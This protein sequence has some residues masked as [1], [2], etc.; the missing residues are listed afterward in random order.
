MSLMKLDAHGLST[1]AAFLGPF[2]F[3]L[4]I[5]L[6][7]FVCMSMFLTIINDSF[8]TVRDDIKV[9][10]HGDQHIFSLMFYKFQCFIGRADLYF[11]TFRSGT[12]K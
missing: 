4:F 10:G 6:V 7:V 11:V 2:C 12:I 5:L 1:A 3:T 8:R 9:T